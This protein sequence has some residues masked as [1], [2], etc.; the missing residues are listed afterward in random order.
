[1]S[2]EKSVLVGMS[3]GIDST[4]V[5]HMLLSQ[6]YRVVGLTFIT[7][8]VGESAAQSARGPMKTLSIILYSEDAVCAMIAGM[9]YFISSLPIFSVPNSA[10][11]FLFFVSFIK[12]YKYCIAHQTLCKK[13]YLCRDLRC[14]HKYVCKI[15]KKMQFLQ[16]YIMYVG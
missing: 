11:T 3:G 4:A 15:N 13:I 8:D 5:C 16:L 14:A 10:G 9:A 7:C 6:G 2:A 1:M 12:N